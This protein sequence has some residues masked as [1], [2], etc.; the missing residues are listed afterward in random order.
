MMKRLILH[1]TAGTHTVNDQD[2]KHYHF[3][4]GGDGK[5]FTGKLTPKDNE[6]V[7]DGVYAAHTWNGNT[8][9]I[10]VA[11]AAMNGAKERPF[12]QS[13]W[14]ITPAQVDALVTL[15]ADLCR[16]YSIPVTRET[17]LTHAE[18]EPT[19]KI[20]QRGKWDITWLPGMKA[21][22]DP[23]TVGDNLRAQ[24]TAAMAPKPALVAAKAPRT[25]LDPI[26]DLFGVLK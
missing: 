18:V 10:G 4:I 11:V 2:R 24:I 25:W 19:L 17:V 12:V 22:G 16:Q 5:V 7:Q 13:K 20:K 14:P 15:C 6:N 1:W 9:S 26:L 8:G 21:P 23:V 3:V